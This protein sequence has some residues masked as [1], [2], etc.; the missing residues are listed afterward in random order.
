MR[1]PIAL[2]VAIVMALI[3]QGCFAGGERDC[4][5]ILYGISIPL[6]IYALV[7]AKAEPHKEQWIKR[8]TTSALLAVTALTLEAVTL[9]RE[10]KGVISAKEALPFYVLSIVIFALAILV[11]DRIALKRPHISRWETLALAAIILLA[12]ALRLYRLDSIPPGMWGDEANDG[13]EA[14]RV[15]SGQFSTPF[16]TDWGGNP[17]MKAF[18]NAA[19]FVIFGPT[20]FGL[21]VV[22]A[23]FGTVSIFLTYLL[24][25]QLFTPRVALLSGF[26]LTVSRWH[27]HRSRFDSVV[28]QALPFELAA[29]FFLFRGLKSR[30][31]SDFAWSGLALGFGLNFYHG[32]R[33]VPFI[34]VALLVYEILRDRWGFIRHYC[35]GLMVLLIAALV[36]FA[37]LGLVFLQRPEALVR[38]AR[39]VWLFNN[40][41]HFRGMYPGEHSDLEMA[42]LQAKDTLLMFNY[43]GDANPVNNWARE[44]MLDP[45]TAVLFVLGLAYAL[46]RWKDDRHFFLLS[47]LFLTLLTGSVLTIGA[48]QTARTTG[49][50]PAVCIL[51]ALFLDTAGRELDRSLARR[52]RRCLAVIGLVA[53]TIIGYSNVDTHFNKYMTSNSA[54]YS[55]NGREVELAHYIESLGGD[56]RVYFLASQFAHRQHPLLRFIAPDFEGYDFWDTTSLVPIRERPDRG[57]VYILQEDTLLPLLESYYPQGE[58]QEFKSPF[59]S[60]VF[61]SYRVEGEEVAAH[62]GLVGRYWRGMERVGEPTLERVDETIAFDWATESPLA[63]PFSAEWQGMIYVSLY[64]SHA[65]VLE[66]DEEAELIIDGHLIDK[67][68]EVNLARGLHSIVVR[69]TVD[70]RAGRLR[71]FWAPPGQELALV[72][73]TALSTWQTVNGLLGSYY[74]NADWAGEPAFQQ[75]DPFICF[76]WERDLD[77][78]RSPFSVEWESDI[79]IERPGR[80]SFGTL[81][82]NGSWLYVDGQLVVDNGGQHGERYQEGSVDLE[83]GY[84]HLVLRYFNRENWRMLQL[85]WTPPGEQRKVILPRHLTPTPAFGPELWRVTDSR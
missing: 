46:Y 53:L 10:A 1:K 68:G 25:R 14:L 21:R 24:A 12:L 38:R 42:M 31:L 54:Y 74:E 63:A 73:P 48:P 7:G 52:D 30:R 72:S 20:I 78:L 71:L 80:Y 44:P 4:A 37:P 55:F 15:L 61:Y 65:F 47:W 77:P 18:V 36:A 27:I 40:K 22:A 33:I 5:L 23:I 29:F 82:S 41:A 66:A 13:L 79:Y 35:L 56:Y 76:R 49:V 85:Y 69:C 39:I 8:K 9:F 60:P 50:I 43:K 62:Q 58:I 81:S 2:L 59:G 75:V 45:V 17:A 32:S 67:T 3:A 84:H 16:T 6:A 51:A 64:G 28:I 19:S 70:A 26:L 57:L 11:F 83:S 34:V